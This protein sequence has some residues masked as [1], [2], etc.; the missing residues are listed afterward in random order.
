ML[1]AEVA[2]SPAIY[3]RASGLWFALNSGG[4]V[5]RIDGLGDATDVPVQ[6]R[7]TLF[8]AG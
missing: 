8:G 1:A 6:Q 5:T 3:N 7:P 4:G 2:L